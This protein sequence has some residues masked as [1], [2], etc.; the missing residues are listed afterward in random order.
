MHQTAKLIA[1]DWDYDKP[2]WNMV[3]VNNY[4]GDGL[5]GSC[6]IT[7]GHHTL[8]DGQGFIM[9]QL[10]ISSYGE[11]LQARITDGRATISSAR[12]G[13]AQPSKLHKGLKPLDRFQDTLLLQIVMFALFWLVAF[14]SSVLEFLGGFKQGFS[15]AMHF[16]TDGWRARLLTSAYEGPRVR[17]REFATS[18]AVPMSDV[19]VLQR[20]FS[21][22][23]PGGWVS[24]ALGRKQVSWWGHLTLNDI[25]CTVSQV[26]PRDARPLFTTALFCSVLMLIFG[27]YRFLL[28]LWR[29]SSSIR[30]K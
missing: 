19:R 23:V 11:E 29:T 20:A 4:K 16:L 18:R 17:E 25:F 14:A 30:R 26:G 22:P 27:L 13:T 24:K 3:I 28:I 9:S 1:S 10:Y 21:G 12:R 15:F 8:T 7:R 6:I 2:L 5:D